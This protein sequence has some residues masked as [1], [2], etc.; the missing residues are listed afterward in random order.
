MKYLTATISETLAVFF[1]TLR[2]VV[3][4]CEMFMEV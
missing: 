1:G 4:R 3:C 2:R